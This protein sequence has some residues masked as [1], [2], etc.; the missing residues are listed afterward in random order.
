MNRATWAIA[1]ASL[2]WCMSVQAGS[3]LLYDF[4]EAVDGWEHE[5]PEPDPAFISSNYA[6]HGT[7]SLAFTHAFSRDKAPVLQCRVLTGLKND[8]SD[9]A[10][11]GFSAWVFIPSG[12]PNWEVKMFARSGSD[13]TWNAGRSLKNVQPGWHKVSVLRGEITSPADIKD[14]GIQVMNYFETIECTI[15]I[16]AVEQITAAP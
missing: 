9:P 3:L 7:R 2:T 4:E 6:R 11:G 16:D 1:I 15:Y 5:S 13:W 10:F 8:F 14:I 12:K